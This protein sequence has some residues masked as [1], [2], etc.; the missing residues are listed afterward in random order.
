MPVFLVAAAI[1][2]AIFYIITSMYVSIS[3]DLKRLES[4]TRS[5]IFGM[6]GESLNGITTIRAYGD[7]PRFFRQ[8][9]SML[10]DNARPYW[11][12]W[13]ANRWCV[14]PLLMRD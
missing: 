12:L 14:V 11:N 9:F 3:R 2:G 8:L 6:V 13:L 5:P 10:D 7:G 4:V 1:L